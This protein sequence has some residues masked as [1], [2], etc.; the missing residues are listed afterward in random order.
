MAQDGVRGAFLEGMRA[1]APFL[2]V[3]GPFGLIFGLVAREAGLDM[4]EILGM[5]VLVIAGASQITA[6]QLMSDQAPTLV[7]ILAGLAV[8]LRLALYSASLAPHLEG[9]SL[10]RRAG[11][12]YW[13]T[14]QT[15]GVAI[16][17]FERDP[18][19]TPG[20][21]AAYFF[22]SGVLICLPWYAFTV[23][24]ALAGAR[25]PGWLALDFAV[26]VTFI[27]LFAPVLRSLPHLA[28]AAVS[29]ALA[30]SFAWLPYSLGLMVAAICA[31]AAGALVETWQE[32]RA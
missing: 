18:G 31:M 17:R 9:M 10:L 7:V 15:F 1:G 27:A 12:A 11:A 28:A 5:S 4:A 23:V 32:G 24:G 8:N 6:V 25:I 2:L 29:V 16:N 22:G 21:R 30:L 14:D 13:L 3:V 20:R 19:M 26:P